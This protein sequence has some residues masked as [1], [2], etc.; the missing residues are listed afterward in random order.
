MSDPENSNSPHFPLSLSIPSL[1]IPLMIIL[2]CLLCKIHA[3]LLVLSILL[4]SL[5]LWGVACVFCILWPLSTYS[6]V[7]TMTIFLWLGYLTLDIIMK[8]HLFACKI[9]DHFVSDS[10]IVFHYVDVP[11]FLYQFF[12]WW[13]SHVFSN[14]LLFWIKL[15]RKT[16]RKS[17]VR[18]WSIFWL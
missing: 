8:S 14:Y 9:H 13:R 15:F 1:H 18:R 17:L 4:V 3:S 7:Q 11:H 2:F 6:C 10:W 16:L 5:G 12:S